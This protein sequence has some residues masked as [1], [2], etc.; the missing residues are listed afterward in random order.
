MRITKARRTK[1][2]K[3]AEWITGTGIGSVVRVVLRPSPVLS[4]VVA[5]RA[6]VIRR[7]PSDG[8]GRRL[9]A[10][11]TRFAFHGL[12]DVLASELAVGVSGGSGCRLPIRAE[13]RRTPIRGELSP[14]GRTRL[15]IG[16]RKPRAETRSCGGGLSDSADEQTPIASAPLRASVAPCEVFRPEISDFWVRTRRVSHGDAE[17]RRRRGRFGRRADSD[18][19]RSS[20]CLRGSV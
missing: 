2:R 14:S 15:A 10:P 11:G 7:V 8:W 3:G 16:A 20:P 17:T 18:C 12:R 9:P 19:V 4:R 5:F 13:R 1:T 6:F